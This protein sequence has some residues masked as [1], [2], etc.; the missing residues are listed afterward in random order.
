MAVLRAI[1]ET[2]TSN[3]WMGLL[4]GIDILKA[5]VNTYE[6]LFADRQVQAMDAVR[7]VENDTLGRVPMATIC[8]QRPPATDDRL[9]HSPHLG[10]HT[11]EI[12]GEWA[13]V[14]ATAKGSRLQVLWVAT[15]VDLPLKEVH[16]VP[17]SSTL[18]PRASAD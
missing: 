10:E 13:L 9:T 5:K 18:R 16:A 4:S 15:G 11:R 7:W 17:W 1:F 14:R 6:D 2:K 12:L 8:G 3:E